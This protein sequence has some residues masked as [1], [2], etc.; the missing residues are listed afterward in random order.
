MLSIQ[1]FDLELQKIRDTANLQN[2]WRRSLSL[3]YYFSKCWKTDVKKIKSG[4]NFNSH[5][6]LTI[7]INI[8]SHLKLAIPINIMIIIINTPIIS[9]KFSQ[10][11]LRDIFHPLIEEGENNLKSCL[12][13]SIVL[14]YFKKRVLNLYF[15]A[16]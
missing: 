2:E 9:Q 4:G 3:K 12:F 7:P 11:L 16:N 15:R 5:L 1:K 6:K 14:V 13:L 8:I 10:K